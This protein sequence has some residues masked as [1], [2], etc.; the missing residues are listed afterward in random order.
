VSFWVRNLVASACCAYAFAIFAPRA[1]AET[2]EERSLARA[3]AVEGIQAFKEK[4]FADAIDLLARAEKLLHAPTHVLYLARAHASLGHLVQ[5][6]ELYTRL[7]NEQLPAP[8]PAAFTEAQRAARAE[9]DALIPR[10]PSLRVIVKGADLMKT[11]VTIDGKPYLTA[12]LGVMN[13]VDPGAHELRATAPGAEAKAKTVSLRESEH[14]SVELELEPVTTSPATST[15]ADAP[16]STP[17]EGA[18]SHS[19]V[20]APASSPPP[21]AEAH[22]TG[23]HAMRIGAFASFGVGA[24]GLAVGTVFGLQAKSKDSDAD[25][26][27]RQCGS[28]C[29][30]TNPLA[31]RIESLDSDSRKARTLSAVG[32][33]TAG[34]GIAGGVVL[35]VLT[36]KPHETHASVEHVWVTA[37]SDEIR[38]GGDW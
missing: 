33:V 24:V 7:S 20:A 22:S 34:V 14:Q 26:L 28:P 17:S 9:L 18:A 29:L 13:P 15:A 3:A 25:G 37:S 12:A 31:P 32:F 11:A 19:D 8:V 30:A 1:H 10:I 2:D 6:R 4:R 35:F 21:P 16:S 5:A 38:L 23:M 36:P 27:A